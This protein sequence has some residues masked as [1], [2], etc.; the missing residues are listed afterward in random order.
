MATT[1]VLPGQG[2]LQTAIDAAAP[3]DTISLAPGI[4]TGTG[5]AAGV[6]T[7]P[8]TITGPATIDGQGAR[9]GLYVTA[10]ALN[11]SGVTFLNGLGTDSHLPLLGAGGGVF[12]AGRQ[13][14]ATFTNCY[15][16]SCA[17][18]GQPNST[19]TGGTGAGG[20][21]AVFGESG[22]VTFDNVTIDGCSATGALGLCGGF[23]QGG[24]FFTDSVT[25]TGT[26]SV[27]NCTATGGQSTGTLWGTPDGF[28]AAGNCVGGADPLRFC[29]TLKNP[30]ATGNRAIGGA[31]SGPGTK[32]GGGWGGGFAFQGVTARL[33]GG[34]I[35]GNS[36]IGGSGGDA[37]LESN[38]IGNGGGLSFTTCHLE[39]CN[40]TVTN[41][42]AQGGMGGPM[43]GGSASGGGISIYSA[44]GLA[45]MI[46]GCVISG[47]SL[48]LARGNN[49][50]ESGSC[51]AGLDVF[52][53][54]CSVYE[55]TFNA[56]A[57]VGYRWNVQGQAIDARRGAAVTLVECTVTNHV[58]SWG[59]AAI[60]AF[61]ADPTFN[62]MPSSVSAFGLLLGGNSG[63]TFGAFTA[64]PMRPMLPAI[65]KAGW[66][67]IPGIEPFGYGEPDWRPVVGDWRGTGKFGIGTITD[68]GLV[69]VKYLAGP[70]AAD[71]QFLLDVAPGA[72][73]GVVVLVGRL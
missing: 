46:R 63:G 18:I 9:H 19:G 69:A 3:S 22:Q 58:N 64:L 36:S 40:V 45:S 44:P 42:T 38:R 31:G 30:V 56:N 54:P 16:Q 8:L 33:Y 72:A 71:D 61:K 52:G 60:Y 23:G 50:G 32:C 7:K 51:G 5:K 62:P 67:Y 70:G 11:V 57:L 37:L 24:G 20:G 2:T 68:R 10:D 28:G 15:W 21:L 27:T 1:P 55:T 59:G 53:G 35:T 34:M 66:W 73:D 65:Y 29:V 12:L 4:Y 6:I 47:N 14:D 17:A 25:V 48:V 39:L 49:E 13:I 43:V 26:M 41:N